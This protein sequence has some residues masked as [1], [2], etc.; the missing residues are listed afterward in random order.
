LNG[1]QVL[2]IVQ[3]K[4]KLY[5]IW[6]GYG[7][8]TK[9]AITDWAYFDKYIVREHAFWENIAYEMYNTPEYWWIVAFFNEIQ[10]PFESLHVGQ[11]LLILKPEFIPTL[12]KQVQEVKEL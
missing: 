8:T 10:N 6:R 12:L 5:N 3:N 7:L 1:F 11:E 4:Q 9:R 2:E